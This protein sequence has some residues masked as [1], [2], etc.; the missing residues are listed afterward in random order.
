MLIKEKLLERMTKQRGRR[1]I[2]PPSP[3]TSQRMNNQE[4]K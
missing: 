1:E 3:V 2:T 4:I